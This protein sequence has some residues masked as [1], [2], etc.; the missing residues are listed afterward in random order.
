MFRRAG[1]TPDTLS[2]TTVPMEFDVDDLS[3]E[4]FGRLTRAWQARRGDVTTVIKSTAAATRIPGLSEALPNAGFIYVHR[5]PIAVA[6]SLA[7]VA[8]FPTM[9]LWWDP[10]R[11]TPVGMGADDPS[12]LAVVGLAHVHQQ[13]EAATAGLHRV[14]NGRVFKLSYEH[15]ELEPLSHF[16]DVDLA[17]IESAFDGFEQSRA[18]HLR[19]DWEFGETLFGAGLI[20]RLR[21][22][23]QV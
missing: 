16:L 9:R 4:R 17:S 12:R 15:P 22:W 23:S 18:N 1:L 21:G 14:A 8:F 20:D 2:P 13:S 7:R 6:S 11:R 19:P 3:F 10:E 5:N